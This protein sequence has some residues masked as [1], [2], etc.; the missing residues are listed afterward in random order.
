MEKLNTL[1]F[2]IWADR[3]YGDSLSRFPSSAGAI[4]AFEAP[5]VARKIAV[6]TGSES[7][8]LWLVE[9]LGGR[10]FEGD[11]LWHCS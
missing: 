4:V 2:E 8:A 7:L 10:F 1:L 3:D 11:T 9:R 5:K 6:K